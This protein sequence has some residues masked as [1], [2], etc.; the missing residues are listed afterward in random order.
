MI[1]RDNY[2]LSGPVEIIR[3]E[4]PVK[5]LLDLRRS[6]IG[7]G[8]A[9]GAGKEGEGVRVK[10]YVKVINIPL[11]L[12]TK[13]GNGVARA[14][15]TLVPRRQLRNIIATPRLRPFTMAVRESSVNK[16]YFYGRL[17]YLSFLFSLLLYF[18]LHP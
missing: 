9:R 13:K 7:R 17:S 1:T 18:F 15:R 5:N 12:R 6:F 8:Y 16:I 2:P 4:V 3:G 14:R 11:E 10:A